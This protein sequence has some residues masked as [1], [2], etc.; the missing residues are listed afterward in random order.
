MVWVGD[1]FGKKEELCPVCALDLNTQRHL[2]LCRIIQNQLSDTK[3]NK[4]SNYEDIFGRNPEKMKNA[5]ND[6]EECLRI[7]DQISQKK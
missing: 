4:Q 2:T 6:F 7:R 1:N 3:E 5:I